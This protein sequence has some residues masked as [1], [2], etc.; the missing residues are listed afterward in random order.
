MKFD[1]ITKHNKA[2]K[3]VV[4]SHKSSGWVE[5]YR[6]VDGEQAYVD[7]LVMGAKEGYDKALADIKLHILE[8]TGV[9]SKY[10]KDILID[11]ID[12]IR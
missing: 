11:I 2:V 4:E 5:S 1:I 9:P 7:G 10:Q 12:S 3:S 6:D 8:M